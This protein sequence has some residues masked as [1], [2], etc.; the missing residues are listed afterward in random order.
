M[1]TYR[2]TQRNKETNERERGGGGYT[3][4]LQCGDLKKKKKK[5]REKPTK[6]IT[7]KQKRKQGKI[8]WNKATEK[9]NTNTFQH[10]EI[11]N[12]SKKEKQKETKEDT[13]WMNE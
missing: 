9:M 2:Q 11:E 12:N 8:I 3:Y 10:A 13:Y 1:D 6:Q 5:Q 7:S 4:I